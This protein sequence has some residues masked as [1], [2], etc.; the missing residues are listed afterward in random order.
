MIGNLKAVK[1]F[2][3]GT[4]KTWSASDTITATEQSVNAP[5]T[6]AGRFY[7]IQK[8]TYQVGLSYNPVARCDSDGVLKVQFINPTAGGLTATAAEAWVGV[9]LDLE[10]D[11]SQTN[12]GT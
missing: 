3:F 12:A 5:G 6:I 2:T 9:C 8:P 10:L 7:L 4:D 11:P 1:R